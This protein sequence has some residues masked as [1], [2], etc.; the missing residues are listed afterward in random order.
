MPASGSSFENLGASAFQ[1]KF[2]PP[3]ATAPATA[4]T[5]IDTPSTSTSIS[6]CRLKSSQP[7]GHRLRAAERA[8]IE[9]QRIGERRAQGPRQHR[10]GRRQ[11][12]DKGA[13][14]DEVRQVTR[15]RH[16]PFGT[17]LADLSFG[18]G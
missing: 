15:T 18:G 2:Q 7:L 17:R 1:L 12:A 16:L 9:A 13:D 14:G 10:R 3:E 11:H 8:G 4:S 6:G 5:I